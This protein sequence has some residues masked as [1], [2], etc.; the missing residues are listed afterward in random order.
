MHM[1]Y[2]NKTRPK[3]LL[4]KYLSDENY[5][6]YGMA[7]SCVLQQAH[8]YPRSLESNRVCTGKREQQKWKGKEP[9]LLQAK[10]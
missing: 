1:R 9:G 10:L 8:Q 6:L 5:R 4:T 2:E 3:I 7:G